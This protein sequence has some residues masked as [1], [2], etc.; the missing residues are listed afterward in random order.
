MY[1]GCCVVLMNEVVQAAQFMILLFE[2][3]PSKP[4]RLK[5]V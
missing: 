5:S 3:Y 1:I 2:L 4:Y